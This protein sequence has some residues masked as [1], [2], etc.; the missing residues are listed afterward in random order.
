MRE[1]VDYYFYLIFFLLFLWFLRKKIYHFFTSEQHEVDRVVSEFKNK[2][3]EKKKEEVEKILEE[4][5]QGDG[6]KI[7][8]PFE[9]T[10][11]LLRNYSRRSV[12]SE[13]GTVLISSLDS[14]GKD[15]F[16]T[17]PSEE[18]QK[19]ID[20]SSIKDSMFGVVDIKKIS[21]SEMEITKDDGSIFRFVDEKITSVKDEKKKSDTDEVSEKKSI[22]DETANVIMGTVM[23]IKDALDASISKKQEVEAEQDDSLDI[24]EDGEEIEMPSCSI[25]QNSFDEV[26]KLNQLKTNQDTP[27]TTQQKSDKSEESFSKPSFS[28]SK[29]A[30][31]EQG[32]DIIESQHDAQENNETTVKFQNI[33]PDETEETK[34][35]ILLDDISANPDDFRF[36]ISTVNPDIESIKK[37]NSGK[38]KKINIADDEIIESID[39][40]DVPSD[41]FEKFLHET[42]TDYFSDDNTKSFAKD[43]FEHLDD[44]KIFLQDNELLVSQKY[45]TDFII[46]NLDPECN[47]CNKEAMNKKNND[48]LGMVLER[49]NFLL[50]GRAPVFFKILRNADRYI[51]SKERNGG[52]LFV[53][54]K[55]TDSRDN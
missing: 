39:L 18:E 7:K 1:Y 34:E 15:F 26:V 5:S 28:F 31:I 51:F 46:K 21:E 9:Q 35:D 24:F 14:L 20:V 3:H 2:K 43:F 10:M 54:I 49:I 48:T 38:V 17:E 12:V 23:G 40:E 16:S 47:I 4:I 8:L 19:K 37:H 11:F 41:D 36:D 13:D 44:D 53:A 29:E 33:K 25:H 22:Q 50:Q 6:E 42:I 27:K 30:D 32:A 55:K 45:L 52:L